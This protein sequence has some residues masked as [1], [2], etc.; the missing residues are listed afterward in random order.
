MFA[1]FIHN[2]SRIFQKEKIVAQSVQAKQERTSGRLG[3][4]FD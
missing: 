3:A 4:R 1:E 2:E